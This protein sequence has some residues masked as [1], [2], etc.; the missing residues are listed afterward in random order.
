MKGEAMKKGKTK[1]APPTEEEAKVSVH[2]RMSSVLVPLI[3]SRALELDRSASWVIN[4]VL[5]REWF[6]D[7]KG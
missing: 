2:F 1:T 5:M 4:D 7:K 6:G 3:T